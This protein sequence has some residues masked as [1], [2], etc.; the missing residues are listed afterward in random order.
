MEFDGFDRLDDV[1]NG[2]NTLVTAVDELRDDPP[3]SLKPETLEAL[4]RVLVD[5]VRLVAELEEQ[6]EA[7]GPEGRR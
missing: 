4:R 3:P 1:A 2:L 6:N 5:A 7:G